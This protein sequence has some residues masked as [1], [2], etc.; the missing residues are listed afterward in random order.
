MLK[1]IY[2]FLL[3]LRLHYQLLILSG[4][5][6]LGGYF[7][8]EM[9]ADRF[10]VQFLNV[11]ILLFGGATAYN[12]WWDKDKGPVGGLKHPPEMAR[13]MH[14]V[15]LILMFAGLLFAVSVGAMYAFI[16]L[17]SL[18]LFWLYSTPLARWKSDPHLSM[19]AIG[20][21]TGFNSVLMGTLAAGGVISPKLLFGAAG[22]SLILLSLY[23]VSQIFQ[24]EEDRKRKDHTFALKYGVSGVKSFFMIAFITGS[25]LLSGSIL[26]QSFAAGILLIVGTAVSG[27]IIAYFILKMEGKPNEYAI[28]M[29]TK[30][31]ASLS[32]VCF[33][34]A[35]NVVRHG[36]LG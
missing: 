17:I 34:L 7:A 19:A 24:I 30:F 29:K 5:F 10:W 32:F 33:F 35:G 21:S 12:S 28:V 11:H 18:I 27:T 16:F 22:A 31:F 1:E 13:W 23:P 8:G 26:I 4:G 25:L 2:N 6:L 20:I 14:P 3:H 15:S 9:D 36:W